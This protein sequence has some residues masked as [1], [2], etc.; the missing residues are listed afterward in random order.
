MSI[1]DTIIFTLERNWNRGLN[2]YGGKAVVNTLQ[3]KEMIGDMLSKEEKQV[4]KH[5]QKY[6]GQRDMKLSSFLER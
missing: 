1:T 5:A 2:H 3:F 6:L 4:L